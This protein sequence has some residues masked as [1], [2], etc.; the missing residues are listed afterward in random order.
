M[1]LMNQMQ[2]SNG[3]CQKKKAVE[4]AQESEYFENFD[5]KVADRLDDR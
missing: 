5:G 4:F 2:L 1:I 3:H